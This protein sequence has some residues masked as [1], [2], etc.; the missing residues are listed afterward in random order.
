MRDARDTSAR[1][2]WIGLHEW[3][4]VHYAGGLILVATGGT[5]FDVPLFHSELPMRAFISEGQGRFWRRALE[6]P[7]EM[8]FLVVTQ[9]GDAIWENVVTKPTFPAWF[10][11]VFVRDEV[12][13]YQRRS[14]AIPVR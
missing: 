10:K 4:K 1:W 13:V 2:E 7:E 3:L 9:E 12:H 5:T 8:V 14:D 6:H 11:A